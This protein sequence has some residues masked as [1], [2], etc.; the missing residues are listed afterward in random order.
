MKPSSMSAKDRRAITLGLSIV[1]PALFAVFGVK[2]YFAALSEARQQLS[3]EQETLAREQAAVEAAH[4]N[5]RLQQTADSAMRAV[6]PRLFEGRDDVMASAELVSYLGEVARSNHVWLQD[7]A[8][9]PAVLS[10]GGVRALRVEMRAESDLH[11]VI[12]MLRELELGA[13]FV[14]VDRLDISRSSRGAAQDSSE[15]LSVSATVTGYAIGADTAI[16]VAP[17]KTP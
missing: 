2:P 7:A 8:T 15:A 17:R 16:A 1:V 6:K 4:R 14:R 10:P 13:K 3:V 12:T 5:P 11:G 9:R